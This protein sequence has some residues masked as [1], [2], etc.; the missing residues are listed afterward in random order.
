VTGPLNSI[1]QP[2]HLKAALL[3][4]STAPNPT[5]S[6]QNPIVMQLDTVMQ[7]VFGTFATLIGLVGIWFA[8]HTYK[9]KSLYSL[10][11]W[12]PTVPTIHHC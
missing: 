1:I 2:V 12:Y 8:W 5:S 10:L 3:I 4:L 9:G 11:G 6:T 7:I